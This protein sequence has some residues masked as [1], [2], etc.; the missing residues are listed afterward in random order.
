MKLGDFYDKPRVSGARKQ[1]VYD[2]NNAHKESILEEK[3]A[4]LEQKVSTLDTISEEKA[5]LQGKVATISESNGILL[6]ENINL[7]KKMEALEGDLRGQARMHNDLAAMTSRF[8]EL[9][10]NYGTVNQDYSLLREKFG[11][12][13]TELDSLR[14]NNAN[15]QINMRSFMDTAVTKDALIEDLHKALATLSQEHKTLTNFSTELGKKYN[16]ASSMWDKLAEENDNYKETQGVLQDQKEEL[17]KALNIRNKQGETEGETRVRKD[18]DSRMGELLDNMQGLTKENVR[19]RTEL[20]TPQRTSVGAIARQEGFKVPLASA[21]VNYR[22]NTLGS[23]K[24]TL[25][26]FANKELG[27]DN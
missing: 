21:A 26:R 12:Q 20:S 24:P 17:T 23:G 5:V 9:S 1:V 16:E 2:L 6:Q 18:M 13:E 11:L 27:D 15:L 8:E 19:L 4:N 3:I 22:K 25:L 10:E 7:Q 14:V